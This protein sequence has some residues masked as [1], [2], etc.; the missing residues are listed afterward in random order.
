MTIT[1]GNTDCH[2]LLDCGSSCTIINMSL[3]KEIMFNCTQ[4][5]WS[6]KKPLDFKS[7]SNNIIETLGTIK[8]PVCCN[9]WKFQK[10][11]ITVVA[12]G[13]RP[14]LGRDLF[15]HLGITISQKSCPNIEINNVENFCAIKNL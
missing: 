10:A 5:Q 13:S 3:A 4:A 1:I 14:I 9:N 6:E 8:T 7:F 12:D 15:E 2:L 11:K